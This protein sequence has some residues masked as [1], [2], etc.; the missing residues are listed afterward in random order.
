MEH[1]PKIL[2]EKGWSLNKEQS[3]LEKTYHFKTYTKV[4]VSN[5]PEYFSKANVLGSVPRNCNEMQIRKSPSNNDYGT[6]VA[7]LS[8]S[9][10]L[11][12]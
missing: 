12:I 3:Q 10:T 11:I 4:N 9:I 5:T 2:L 8:F 7:R 6:V 1:E